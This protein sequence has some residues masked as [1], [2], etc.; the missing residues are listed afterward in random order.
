MMTS[1]NK[2]KGLEDKKSH[3]LMPR[4]VC[5][6]RIISASSDILDFLSMVLY[7]HPK[8]LLQKKR[9]SKNQALLPQYATQVLG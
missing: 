5:L 2:L 3:C 9:P 1:V 6:T 7:N 4:Q 8:H